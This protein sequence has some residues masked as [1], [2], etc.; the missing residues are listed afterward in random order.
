MAGIADAHLVLD[1]EF[2]ASPEAVERAYR[3]LSKVWHPDR[4]LSESTT[5]QQRA[6]ERQRQI[7]EAHEQLRAYHARQ[8]SAAPL[9]AR[10]T[11]ETIILNPAPA[12]QPAVTRTDAL[13]RASQFVSYWLGPL[14]RKVRLPSE[15]GRDYH[16]MHAEAPSRDQRQGQWN[17]TG[18]GKQ[19]GP[20]RQTGR[21]GGRGMGPRQSRRRRGRG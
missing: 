11:G 5:L 19:R 12:P 9:E 16:E 3:E 17:G 8:P 2:G 7:N 6:Q 14:L 4:F 20:G 10:R 21:G 18:R 1:L 13:S 15:V